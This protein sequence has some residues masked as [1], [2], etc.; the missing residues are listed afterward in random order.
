MTPRARTILIADDN[1]SLREAIALMLGRAGFSCLQAT[2]GAEA[3]RLF[4]TH[5]PDLVILD[6]MMPNVDGMDACREIRRTDKK[7]P[8]L[9]LTAKA[10]IDDKR[11]GFQTGA[12]DWL[13]KPFNG[14]ELQLRVAALLRR[15]YAAPAAGGGP[16]I[17]RT[18]EL[19]VDLRTRDVR[20][21]GQKIDLTPKEAR[22]VAFLAEHPDEV[23]TKDELVEHIW[24]A[25]YVGTAISISTYIRRIRMKI[26]PDSATPR[27]LQTVW[28][29]GYRLRSGA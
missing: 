26:E 13:V 11:E 23:F 2:D 20:L 17:F 25:E 14:E 21:R 8:I 18:G 27:Y 4:S 12:D 3:L 5:R 16:E 15:A 6:V 10:G 9:F 19:E 28:N 7:A 24:G 1:Q 22:I 29:Q